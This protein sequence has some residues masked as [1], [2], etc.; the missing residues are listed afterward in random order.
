MSDSDDKF[1]SL[2][3]LGEFEHEED[4]ETDSLLAEEDNVEDINKNFE[5]PD[6]EDQS[7][8]SFENDSEFSIEEDE[9]GN[10]DAFESDI[11][12]EEDNYI[13]DTE[14]IDSENTD[15]SYENNDDQFT[16]QDDLDE[17]NEDQEINHDFEVTNETLENN[18]DFNNEDQTLENK[19]EEIKSTPTVI[20]EIPSSAPLFQDV[21]TF[22]DNF[23]Y[24]KIQGE[25]NPPY[26]ILLSDITFQEDADYILNILQEYEII[27]NSNKELIEQGLRGHSLIIPRISEYAAIFL[28]HKFRNLDIQLKI[29][30]SH[31]IHPTQKLYPEDKGLV[32]KISI[33]QNKEEDILIS[34][35][36]QTEKDDIIT[37]T[38]NTIESYEVLK[39]L[40]IVSA[41]SFLSSEELE[42]WNYNSSDNDFL[43]SY[44]HPNSVYNKVIDDLKNSALKINGDGIIGINLNLTPLISNNE[45]EKYKLTAT[46]TI[47]LLKKITNL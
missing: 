39:Y 13:S 7:E 17:I 9:D 34:K 36:Q 20:N 19:S 18:N 22:S 16:I 32:S 42:R 33:S 41:H 2:E 38:T 12:N 24:G 44:D 46:G 25:G 35:N 6:N 11:I 21:K 27:N 5:L 29:G 43:N 28:A 45:E 8:S 47:V 3:E 31:E 10:E 15:E 37:S 4:L 1:L 14:Q 26:S 30:L 40:D 23:N